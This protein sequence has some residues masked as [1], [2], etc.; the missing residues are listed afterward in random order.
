LF[1]FQL[2]GLFL[3][4]TAHPAALAGPPPLQRPNRID[5]GC[6]QSPITAGTA[7]PS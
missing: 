7:A 5:P 4:R 6:A 3:L 1:L 2:F